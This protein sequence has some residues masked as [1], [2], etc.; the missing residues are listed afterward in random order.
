VL[1]TGSV[2]LVGDLLAR[3]EGAEALAGPQALG[4]AL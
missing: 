1:A 2:Y 4:E 3:L